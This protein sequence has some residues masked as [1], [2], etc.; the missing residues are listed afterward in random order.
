MGRVY[1][2]VVALYSGIRTCRVSSW[3]LFVNILFVFSPFFEGVLQNFAS[4]EEDLAT[5]E[6]F[7]KRLEPSIFEEMGLGVA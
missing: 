6:T 7:G 5:S 3:V 4:V 1:P 2:S